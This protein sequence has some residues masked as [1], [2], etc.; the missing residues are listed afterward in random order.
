MIHNSIIFSLFLIFAGAAILSTIA[1]YT[2]QSMLVAYILLG[3]IIGPWGLELVSNSE[4]VSG[5][6]EVGMIFLLFLLGMHLPPQKLIHMLKK[7]TWMALISSLLFA[8][9]GYGISF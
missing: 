8:S 7:I 4:F 6:G 5:V 1:L 3:I 2:R 9:V